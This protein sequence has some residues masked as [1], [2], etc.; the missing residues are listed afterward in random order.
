MK[1][2]KNADTFDI[3]IKVNHLSQCKDWETGSMCVTTL[4]NPK[5][6]NPKASNPHHK[7]RAGS[8]N[9]NKVQ[10]SNEAGG[11]GGWLLIARPFV[12]VALQHEG[13]VSVWPGSV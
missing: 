3:S 11:W 12:P 6:N 1:C 5:Q 8:K 2:W 7:T 9:R 13:A 4:F 10:I